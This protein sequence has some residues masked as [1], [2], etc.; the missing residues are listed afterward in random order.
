MTREEVCAPWMNNKALWVKEHED[1][2]WTA[3]LAVARP[4]EPHAVRFFLDGNREV[5][6]AAPHR[7]ISW[8]PTR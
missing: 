4:G 2:P 3:A 8:T 5:P 7:V 1:S 6:L